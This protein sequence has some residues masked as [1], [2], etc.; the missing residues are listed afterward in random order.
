M[1]VI[2]FAT[3]IY[4]YAQQTVSHTQYLTITET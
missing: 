1:G 2:D 4:S 3:Y